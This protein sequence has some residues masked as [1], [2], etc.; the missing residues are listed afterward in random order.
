MT[1][2]GGGFRYYGLESAWL[3]HMGGYH[4]KNWLELLFTVMAV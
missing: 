4:F 3:A 2:F 1:I